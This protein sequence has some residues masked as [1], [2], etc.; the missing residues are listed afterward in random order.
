[1]VPKKM[2]TGSSANCRMTTL[3]IESPVISTTHIG[4]FME[5]TSHLEQSG[6]VW[7][8]GGGWKTYWP[9]NFG[10]WWISLSPPVFGD[11]HLWGCESHP[12]SPVGATLG[13]DE[14]ANHGYLSTLGMPK[15]H[16][17]SPGIQTSISW[18][19]AILG[20]GWIFFCYPLTLVERGV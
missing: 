18:G 2:R 5:L 16:G 15:T 20:L 11:F 6:A 7:S 17:P 13:L 1:M 4:I 19:L 12:W 3:N 10:G 9:I 8:C 14:H